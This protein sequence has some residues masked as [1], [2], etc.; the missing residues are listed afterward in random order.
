MMLD[1]DSKDFFADSLLCGHIDLPCRE[2]R[3][4]EYGKAFLWK[5]NIWVL[6]TRNILNIKDL[7]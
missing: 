5:C 3:H 1:A 7:K 6:R 4:V 2:P